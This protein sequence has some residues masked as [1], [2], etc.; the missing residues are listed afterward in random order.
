MLTS[1]DGMG[2]GTV[3]VT[4]DEL[5]DMAALDVSAAVDVVT[6]HARARID[7]SNRHAPLTAARDLLALAPAMAAELRAAR[8]EIERLRG[9]V[10]ELP[11]RPPEGD[12]VPRYGLRWGGPSQPVAVPMVDGYWTPWHLAER[13]FERLRTAAADERADAV[14]W[15]M[16]QGRVIASNAINRGAHVGAARGGERG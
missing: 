8:I 14:A 13:E 5:R 7:M 10:P 3:E 2:M 9:L 16:R 15:L 1:N 12:G 11:P 4:D 6:A